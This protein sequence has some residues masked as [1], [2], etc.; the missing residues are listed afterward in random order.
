MWHFTFDPVD[1]PLRLA[2]IPFVVLTLCVLVLPEDPK[3]IA[4][5][6]RVNAVAAVSAAL[7]AAVAWAFNA[8]WLPVQ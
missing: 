1:T 5:R 7:T 3:Q 2:F 8:T 4:T 6:R